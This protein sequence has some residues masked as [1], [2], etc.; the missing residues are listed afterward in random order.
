M[1]VLCRLFSLFVL[2]ENLALSAF[3]VGPQPGQ[4]KNLV[5]FGDSYTDIVSK[6]YENNQTI[7]LLTRM[8]S[9]LVFRSPGRPRRRGDSLARLRRLI[10]QLHALPLRQGRRDLLQR[11]HPPPLPLP[12]RVP[13]PDLLRREGQRVPRCARAGAARDGVHAVDRDERRG[14]ERAADGQPDSW[15]HARGH[16]GLRGGLGKGA[17]RWRRAELRLP[18]RKYPSCRVKAD[19]TR[20][21]VHLTHWHNPDDPA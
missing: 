16:G 11:P 21:T 13:A 12:L 7:E 1:K 9:T 17:V 3:A 4:I 10:R 14:R 20:K 18:E 8:H 15:G 5:T 2:A 6:Q 19:E